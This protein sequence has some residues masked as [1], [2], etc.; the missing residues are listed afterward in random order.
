MTRRT[1]M[2]QEE[3]RRSNCSALLTY[4]HQ[5]GPTTRARLTADLGLNRSTI[6]DLTGQLADWGMVE[7]S[8]PEVRSSGRASGRPSLLV[9]PRHQVCVLAV[10]L[11]VDRIECA[12]VGLGGVVLERRVRLHQ[13]GGHDVAEVVET[14]ALLCEEILA[15]IDGRCLGLGVSVPGSVRARDGMV[16]FAP[17]LGW[18]DAPFTALMEARLELPVRTGN[19]ANLGAL[20]EHLR[21]AA[22]GF[23]EVAYI[24]GSVGI[25]GG[26]I[27]Q[28]QMLGGALGYAG[29]VGHLP[30]DSGGDACRCGSLGCWETKIGSNQVLVAAGRLPGGGMV[31]IE[32]V[33]SAAQA[34]EPRAARALS[35]AAQWVGYGLRSVLR[36]FDPSMVVLG[37]VLGRLYEVCGAEV[38]DSLHQGSGV[39]L[40]GSIEVRVAAL[41]LDAPLLGAAE[42]AFEQLLRDPATVG[43]P[44]GGDGWDRSS[45]RGSSSAAV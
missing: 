5:R 38:K 29:E 37:G 21:G 2:S 23:S 13:P 31:A 22:V 28:G 34:G 10:T 35:D 45:G 18:V 9:S 12:L 15:V 26:F 36:L 6:G 30:V 17:N 16:R 3:L 25:G 32:E 33:V 20:A 24:G 39:D 42:L 19:D 41:G 7:E 8:A 4:V 27:V 1:G 11:D 43:D 44:D 40:A 14:V